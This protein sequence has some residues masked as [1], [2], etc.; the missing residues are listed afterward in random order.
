MNEGGT[1]LSDAGSVDTI[2]RIRARATFIA[3]AANV[4]LFGIKLYAGLTVES[5]SLVSEAFN[6]LLDIIASAGIVYSVRVALREPDIDHPIGHRAAEPI[7]S[8][9]YA[10]FAGVVSFNTL[11]ESFVRVFSPTIHSLQ[12]LPF[13]VLA[14]T[15]LIKFSMGKYLHRVGLRYESPALMA[16]AIDAKN[17]VLGS[18]MAIAGIALSYLGYQWCDGMGGIAVSVMIARGGYMIA[19]E[20][21][22]YLMGKAA[23]EKLLL[24]IARRA[25]RIEGVLGVND[26][27]SH[28]VGNRF[29]IEIHIEVDRTMATQHS[30]DIGKRVQREIESLPEVN[31]VFVQIDPV[32]GRVYD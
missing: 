5:I 21:I 12:L 18:L 19:R 22:N 30:H 10:L 23:S 20:N 31:K 29:H 9:L 4:F 24:E 14:V 28:Y 27:R 17:D 32:E 2:H 26:V 16:S 25:Q 6:S 7:T 1:S 11:K 13:V 3:L 15:I 8:L